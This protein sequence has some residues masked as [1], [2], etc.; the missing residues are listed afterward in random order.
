MRALLNEWEEFS[1]YTVFPEYKKDSYLGRFTLPMLLE[2]M[3]FQRILTILAR[4]Y[5]LRD[6]SDGYDRI[7]VARRALLAW[8]SLSGEKTKKA[9]DQENDPRRRVNF[10]EF[11]EEFPELVTPEGDG[12]LIRHVENIIAFVEANPNVVRKGVLEKVQALKTGFRKQWAN[13]LRQMQVP[14]FAS[15][16]KGAWVLR[17]DDILADALELGPLRNRDFDL[18]E[19][20]IHRISELTPKGVPV[21]ASIL[22]YKYYFA[23]KEDNREYVLLPQQNFNAWLGNTNFSQKWIAALNGKSIEKKVLDGVSKYKVSQLL[24]SSPGGRGTADLPAENCDE[25]IVIVKAALG[26]DFGQG[27]FFLPRKHFLRFFHPQCPDPFCDAAA[28][29]LLREFIELRFPDA[30]ILSNPG[31]IELFGEMRR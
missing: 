9:P 25:I 22:L 24:S 21:E 13:K 27:Q 16:T 15:N 12:W 28:V 3:G 8:C 18:P 29:E 1:A 23:S 10:G 20:T 4:G 30:E 2:I 7:D 31:R 19:E 14:A 26:S 11:A 17:F 5:L 6:G